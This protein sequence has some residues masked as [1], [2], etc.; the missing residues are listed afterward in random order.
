MERT[1]H[2]GVHKDQHY[3]TKNPPKNEVIIR[4]MNSKQEFKLHSHLRTT[5][6]TIRNF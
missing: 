1:N 6:L 3:R 5:S 4:N 2:E